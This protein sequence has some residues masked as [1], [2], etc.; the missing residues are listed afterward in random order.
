VLKNI[1]EKQDWHFVL[2]AL[3]VVSVNAVM[4]RFPFY[5]LGE[6]WGLHAGT[7]LWIGIIAA[8]LHQLYVMLIWRTQLETRWLTVNLP[9]IG[10]IA[11]YI[12]YTMMLVARLGAII[13]TATA[14]REILIIPETARWVTVLALVVPCIWLLYSIARHYSFKRLAGADHF[15]PGYRDRSWTRKG[16]F[17]FVPNAVYVFGPLAFYIP[18]ILMASPASLLLALFNHIYVWIHYYCTELPDLRRI[19]GPDGY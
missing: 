5:F 6:S 11:Y 7:W 15:E 14:N 17:R 2:M 12:D 1:F 13:L 18:G 19:Y 9:R 16:I 8:I 10:Y 3:L 4:D